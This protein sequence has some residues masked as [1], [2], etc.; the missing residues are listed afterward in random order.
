M[1]SFVSRTV[2][3]ILL[4]SITPLLLALALTAAL[5]QGRPVIFRQLRAGKGAAPFQLF[6]FRSMR[7]VRNA[8]GHLLPD[9]RR[10]TRF[11]NVLRRTRLDELLGLIN[12]VRGEMAFV[13]PRPLLPETI[14]GLG[15]VGL[16]RCEVRPGL[17]GWSQVNGNTLLTLEQ[18]VALDLWYI[19][20][21]SWLL[22]ARIIMMTIVVM[23]AGEQVGTSRT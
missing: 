9:A 7:D 2:A 3:L 17:T 13:G 21:R 4:A 1:D 22:D 19:G 14:E 20:N 11:G 10:V 12:V 18:K 6:K 15:S 8:A 5:T 16:K 23:I